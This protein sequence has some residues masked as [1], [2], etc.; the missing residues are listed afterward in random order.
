MQVLPKNKAWYTADTQEI[1]VEMSEHAHFP[2]SSLT[3]VAF[4]SLPIPPGLKEKEKG[5]G[6]GLSLSKCRTQ[7]IC[8]TCTASP[9][10]GEASGRTRLADLVS[11]RREKQ[12]AAFQS[13][14]EN[15][16]GHGTQ[17]LTGKR[18]S[19]NFWNL[20]GPVA[21]GDKRKSLMGKLVSLQ[22]YLSSE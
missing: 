3:L 4:P 15:W 8:T 14:Y 7:H 13:V 2:T 11:D 9:V 12:R 19:P 16:V 17:L 21:L 10:A 1:F 18:Q 5:K 22:T 20:Q 6:G